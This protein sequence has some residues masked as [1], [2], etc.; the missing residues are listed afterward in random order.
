M[1]ALAIVATL[2]GTAM[3]RPIL[4][5]PSEAEY[6]KSVNRIGAAVGSVF[7][8]QGIHLLLALARVRSVRVR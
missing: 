8:A 7:L 6:R 2:A 4:E 1:V 5:R 3:A